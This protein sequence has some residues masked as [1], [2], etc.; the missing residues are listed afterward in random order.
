MYR[1][2]AG[3]VLGAA[4]AP[5]FGQARRPIGF[6]ARAR[7]LLGTRSLAAGAALWLDRCSSI[8]MFGMRYPIDLAFL[9][10]GAV[11]KLCPDVR[12]LQVRACRGAEVALEM[13]KGAIE[14]LRLREGDRLSFEPNQESCP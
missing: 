10:A 3:R 8:H 13:P 14:R 7:G 6:L 9:R 11:L 4:G 1:Y 12:P 5:L 2:Q